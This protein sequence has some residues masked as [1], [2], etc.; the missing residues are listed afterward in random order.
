MGAT[1]HPNNRT[2]IL[3]S[4]LYCQVIMLGKRYFVKDLLQ[5]KR[6]IPNPGRGPRRI[7]WCCR[8]PY[9]A[10]SRL[11]Y[12]LTIA[13]TYCAE[14]LYACIGRQQRLDTAMTRIGVLWENTRG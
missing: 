5:Q 11:G 1:Q 2:H 14:M 6:V 3:L 4:Q 9:R 10:E 7:G 8:R 12:A 13:R